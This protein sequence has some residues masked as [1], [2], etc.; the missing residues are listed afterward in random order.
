ML[1]A[2]ACIQ[3]SDQLALLLRYCL[4]HLAKRSSG[5][6]DDPASANQGRD[7][8]TNV[9]QIATLRL[10]RIRTSTALRDLLHPPA[11]PADQADRP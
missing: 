6:G 11:S 5:L 9:R 3:A 10:C 8:Q 2:T 1:R 7:G 4:A